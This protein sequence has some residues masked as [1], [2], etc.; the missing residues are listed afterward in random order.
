MSFLRAFPF[1]KIKIDR[2]F[3]SELAENGLRGDRPGDH[4]A[5]IEPWHPHDGRGV[6]T[7]KQLELLRNEGCTEMQ[8][9]LFSR[10]MPASE[11]ASF[12]T[13]RGSG[14]RP[15]KY[16]SSSQT[17]ALTERARSRDPVEAA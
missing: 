7:E 8:G 9:Y 3:V 2:S 1:D 16:D 10:P 11:I 15:G 14:L 6:E 12:L 5:R 17:P 4:Q 13:S